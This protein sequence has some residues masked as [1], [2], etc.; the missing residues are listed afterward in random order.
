MDCYKWLNVGKFSTAKLLLKSHS[1]VFLIGYLK[2][3]SSNLRGYFSLKIRRNFPPF[4]I[5]LFPYT[6]TE[7][8]IAT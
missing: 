3:K 4:E 6:A 8:C 7:L 1:A 2:E 5:F